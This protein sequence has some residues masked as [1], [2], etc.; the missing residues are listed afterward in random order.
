MGGHVAKS[1]RLG[2]LF[3][4]EKTNSYQNDMIKPLKSLQ[5]T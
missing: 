3:Y 4:F 1:Q 2:F 5:F